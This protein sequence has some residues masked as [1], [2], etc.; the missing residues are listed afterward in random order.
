[1]LS[2][3][4]RTGR[5]LCLLLISALVSVSFAAC[6]GQG[7]SAGGKG[8]ETANAGSASASTD[9][10]I[11]SV[12]D[13]PST[14]DFQC[15]TL[16]YNT[17]YCVFDRLVR[18]ESGHNDL[19]VIRPSLADSWEISDDGREYTFHLREGVRFSNGS[20]L[21]SSDV[22]YTI[23]RL[24]TH[25]ESSNR[26][27]AECILG[28]EE[29][30]NGKSGTASGSGTANTGTLKGFKIIDD[31]DF[32]ITLDEPY[33]AFLAALSMPGASILDEET[34]EAAGD[35]F[36]KDAESTI[37]TGPF[38]LKSWEKGKGML[39]EANPEC[40]AGAPASAGLDVRFVQDSEEV[41]KLFDDGKLDIMDLSDIDSASEYY[42]HGDIYK[43]RLYSA[44][45][46]GI[47]YIALNESKKPLDDVRVRKALQLAL[48]RTM[49]LSSIYGGRGQVENGIYPHGL[50]GFDPDLEAIPYDIKEAASLL[51]QAG[52]ADGFELDFSVRTSST[53]SEMDM[54]RMIADMWSEI[55]VKTNIHVLED[56]EFMELRKKGELAC[57]QATWIADYNDP[58]NF[59]YTFFGN[60]ANTLDRSLCYTDEDVMKRVRRARTIQDPEKRIEE[61]REL[62]RIIVQEDC[63]WVPLLSRTRYYVVSE[64]LE[65]FHVAWTGRYFINYRDMSVSSTK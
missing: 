60:K 28:A 25:P 41:R 31:L 14:V 32:T 36:G 20:E 37:G 15:T 46:V 40:W 51:S 22:L 52:Y 53:R 42:I 62:E 5:I 57:Y 38:I 47:N 17:A 27:I 9:N 61:Y 33:E 8:G 35:D 58:D 21:T 43:D 12:W 2:T 56:D 18:M 34:T 24:L 26:D 16:Y 11:V 65:G 23:T 39:F 3:K 44:P 54:V 1:M 59:V 13:E 64:R 19:A 29:L 6:S 63:A 48:D 49:L 10:Y 45:Q 7:N 4:I 55:G 50:Y 30:E